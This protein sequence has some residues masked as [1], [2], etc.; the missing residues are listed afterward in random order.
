[1]TNPYAGTANTQ[2]M[3][4]MNPGNIPMIASDSS[5]TQMAPAD[6]KSML[7]LSSADI[8]NFTT[9]V[10]ALLSG[11][12]LTSALSSYVLS[13]ALAAYATTS[14]MNAAITAAA[15]NYATSA[16][17]ALAGNSV[18]IG[19]AHPLVYPV[20]IIGTVG[21]STYSYFLKMKKAGTIT[22]FVQA[23]GSLITAG[24][25]TININGTPVSG[26]TS[27]A[28]TTAITETLA[29]GAN[30]YAAGSTISVTI[31]GTLTLI[32]FWGQLS[33]TEAY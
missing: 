13:T 26:L 23:A 7:A 19:T 20:Y 16:Q 4:P 3:L 8:S 32:N 10:Q 6:F 33:V 2:S 24:T 21:N 17:G 27:V 12:V 29:T 31:A 14:A 25:Y 9:A 5:F 11:Y 22:G 18:Q 28:N 1:M 15:S 30:T